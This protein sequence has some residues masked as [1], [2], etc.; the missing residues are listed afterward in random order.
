MNCHK[1][2]Q[3]FYY[4]QRHTGSLLTKAEAWQINLHNFIKQNNWKY[5]PVAKKTAS[6][7]TFNPPKEREINF[8]KPT[9]SP[10]I[11]LKKIK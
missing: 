8:K 2:A 9:L 1:P 11:G 3:R 5:G 6:C 4:L 7:S 10:D